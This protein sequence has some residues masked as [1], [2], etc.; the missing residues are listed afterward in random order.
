M[1]FFLSD[2]FASVFTEE[3]DFKDLSEVNKRW[4]EESYMPEGLNSSEEIIES[5]LKKLKDY[6]ASGIDVIMPKILIEN[7]AS[8]SKPF[9]FLYQNR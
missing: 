4:M 8:L 5:K 1:A 2:F 3:A 9:L 6:K 7:A